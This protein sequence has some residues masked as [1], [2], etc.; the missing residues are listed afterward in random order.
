MHT[1][2]EVLALVALGE[3]EAATPEE[4]DHIAHC[5]GL[6]PGGHRARPPVAGGSDHLRPLHAG[7]AQPRGV[8]PDPGPARLRLRVLPLR[9][10]ATACRFDPASMPG[11]PVVVPLPRCPGDRRCASPSRL[12]LPDLRWIDPAAAPERLDPPAPGRR[13]VLSL[14][15]AA[16]LALLAGIGGTLGLGSSTAVATTPSSPPPRCEALP[17]AW[18]GAT[19]RSPWRRTP[20]ATRSW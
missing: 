6:R 17:D 14:A 5:D 3:R 15:L 9:P 13:R 11:R 18:S 12:R 1:N 7:D 16:V 2:P 10:G 19:G 20:P 8:G 4:L